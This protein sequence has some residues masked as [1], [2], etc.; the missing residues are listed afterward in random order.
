MHS[1]AGAW[2]R[3]K[4]DPLRVE[5]HCMRL[6]AAAIG[7]CLCIQVKETHSMRLCTGLSTGNASGGTK[8]LRYSRFAAN[9][10]NS[11]RSPFIM[12]T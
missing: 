5:T 7:R 3:W 8:R 12:V 1:H 4:Y 10:A 11:E 6:S 2:E 9:S